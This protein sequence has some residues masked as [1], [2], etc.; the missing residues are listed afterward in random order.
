MKTVIIDHL[1]CS[2]PRKL[3]F[4]KTVIQD[5]ETVNGIVREYSNPKKF[6]RYKLMSTREPVKVIFKYTDID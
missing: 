3:L 2:Q 6:P 1:Q 4:S 5:Y